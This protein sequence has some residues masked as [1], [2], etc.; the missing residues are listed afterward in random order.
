[1]GKQHS[2]AELL[3]VNH[4][5]SS[6]IQPGL[7]QID[8]HWIC[9]N[10]ATQMIMLSMKSMVT[11]GDLHASLVHL[12]TSLTSEGKWRPMWRPIEIY[13]GFLGNAC[14]SCSI[15]WGCFAA[16]V[17]G[18]DDPW[19][20]ISFRLQPFHALPHFSSRWW[21]CV[22]WVHDFPWRICVYVIYIYDNMR[23]CAQGVGRCQSLLFGLGFLPFLSGSRGCC[24]LGARMPFG[25]QDG[26]ARRKVSITWE[27]HGKPTKILPFE[28]DVTP[29]LKLVMSHYECEGCFIIGF[30]TLW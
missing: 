10:L 27:R 3:W 16:P 28:D 8:P 2:V 7:I 23:N 26:E 20:S 30:A 6:H 22:W 4:C 1:M 25:N 15:P 18:R 14:C 5:V 21:I 19:R 11:I 9:C 13:R 29:L 17:G 24:Q 12:V